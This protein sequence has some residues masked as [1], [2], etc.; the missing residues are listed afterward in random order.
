VPNIPRPADNSPSLAGHFFARQHQ[1]DAS[2][3]SIAPLDQILVGDL[4]NAAQESHSPIAAR[5]QSQGTILV[6]QGYSS[7]N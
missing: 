3:P 1:P 2:R 6:K 4:S 5:L 7:T